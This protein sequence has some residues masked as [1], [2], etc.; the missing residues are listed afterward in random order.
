MCVLLVLPTDLTDE[1]AGSKL[2]AMNGC[3]IGERG[4]AIV[5]R[6]IGAIGVGR[7]VCLRGL[8]NELARCLLS[9]DGQ[10][11]IPGGPD[12]HAAIRRGTGGLG[13]MTCV[14]K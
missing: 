5:G 9:H 6:E 14:F 10:E 11:Y 8:E 2:N 13:E 1:V 3:I 12:C 4:S 7:S